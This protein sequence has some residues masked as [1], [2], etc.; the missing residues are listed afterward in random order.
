MDAAEIE[1]L[2]ASPLIIDVCGIGVGVSSH[3][4]INIVVYKI[5]SLQH[6]TS[7]VSSLDKYLFHQ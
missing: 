2:F 6:L 1:I 3:Q 4:L 5:N 7:L